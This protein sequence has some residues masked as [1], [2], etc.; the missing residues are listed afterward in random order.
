MVASVTALAAA[1]ALG[2]AAAF[3]AKSTVAIQQAPAAEG[4]SLPRTPVCDELVCDVRL[5]QAPASQ[6]Q[7]SGLVL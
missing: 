7:D 5:E 3:I 1:V 2:G 6:I 4:Y